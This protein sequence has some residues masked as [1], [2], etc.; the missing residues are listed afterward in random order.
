MTGI[1]MKT[2]HV[3]ALKLFMVLCLIF[4]LPTVQ[5]DSTDESWIPVFNFQSKLA[6]QGNV[7]AQFILGEMY[8]NGRG[9]EKNIDLAISWYQKA[10]KNG[11]KKAAKRIANIEENKRN[12]ALAK[13]RAEAEEKRRKEDKARQLVIQK[14]HAREERLRQQALDKAEAKAEAEKLARKN[15]EQKKITP[16][17]RA[18]KIKAAQDRA[19]AIAEKNAMR[20]QQAADA[21]LE[22]YR[23]STLNPQQQKPSKNNDK[24]QDPFE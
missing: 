14:Q 4:H 23:A 18:K 21:E 2:T 1:N 22:R 9:V 19:K 24:Y 13:V 16:E 6:E 3:C 5:A 11:H 7:K 17:E 15:L 10:E 12:E 20:Q 8:E